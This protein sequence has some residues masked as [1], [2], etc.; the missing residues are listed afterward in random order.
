[1]KRLVLALSVL[2]MALVIALTGWASLG[3]VQAVQ[4]SA[5][6][7]QVGVFVDEAMVPSAAAR[8]RV[9]HASPDAPAVDVL[10]NGTAAFTNVA[11]EAMTDYELLPPGNYSLQVVPTGLPGPVVISETLSLAGDTDYTVLAIGQL[12]DNSIEALVLQDDNSAPAA[13]KAHVRFVH[14]SPDA[15]AVDIALASGPVLFSNVAFGEVGSYLPVDAGT[16]DLEVRIAGTGTVVLP[17]PGIPLNADTVYTVVATGLASGTPSLNAVL[18]VDRAPEARVRIVHA[19]PD[20]PAVDI[21]VNGGVAFSN[22]PF[23]DVTDYAA[24]PP[25]TYSV[26]VVPA[27]SSTPVVI[28]ETLTLNSGVDYTVVAIGQLGDNSIEAL[29]LV[30]D[31]STPAP[32]VAHVRFVHTSPDAPAVDI[33]VAGGPVLFSNIDFG[34]VANYLPVDAGTYEL[35]V[36]LAGTN[37][38]VLSL[39]G[40]QLNDRTIYTAFATGLAS[41]TPA[42]N[43]ILS[44][45][46][47]PPARVRVVHASPD[48]PSV[49][50]LADGEIAFSNIA[51]EDVSSYSALSAGSHLV[52]VVP[53]GTT[54]PV[55]ISETLTLNSN[56]DYTIVA[57][58]QL[59]DSSI[60][61]LVLQDDNSLPAVGKAHIR[62]VHA[63]PNA[64]AVDIAVTGGPVLFSNI[65]FGEVG[66]YLPVDAGIYDLEV[67]LTG[68]STV[69]LPLTNVDFEKRTI[70]T[71]FATGLAGGD[72]PLNAVLSLDRQFNVLDIFLPLVFK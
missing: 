64:P 43:A 44:V 22:V 17:L 40:I 69:V 56:T 14:A 28:S 27:G 63:S 61:A 51:F 54:T 13:G 70:Y 11:F 24:L 62:F 10:V 8:I 57:I 20:A 46:S 48:A 33:A 21:L 4:A 72:P 66:A 58:G 49:D 53:N 3:Q 37:T 5:K 45:D 31:N 25:N 59:S 50:V 65:A 52:Q 30:D 41:G 19:S 35:E 9:F 6:M 55:V 71:V 18:S 34:E 15:P 1:M 26:Q 38:V 39:P 42:L 60:E 16:Y 2:S 47:G 23:E 68:T 29:V 32:G 12:G 7:P 67:R 36:R